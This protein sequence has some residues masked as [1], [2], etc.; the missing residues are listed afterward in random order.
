LKKLYLILIGFG[1]VLFMV[2]FYSFNPLKYSFFPKC[3]FR[4]LTNFDC[5]GCGSQRAIH[6]LLHGDI[7]KAADYNLLLVFSLPFLFIH[8]LFLLSGL[9]KGKTKVWA[10]IYK[11]STP[12]VIFIIVLLFW[13]LRNIPVSPFS[14]MAS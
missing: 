13:I 5:P 11:D 4:L 9:N 3:P 8:Y 12:K 14:Y 7:S 2:V 10:L 1:I 6:S